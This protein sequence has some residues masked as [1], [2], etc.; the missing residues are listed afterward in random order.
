MQGEFELPTRLSV[1]A[2]DLILS[3]TEALTRSDSVSNC[4]DDKQK[5]AGIGERNRPVMLLPSTSTKK[6]VNK[7]SKS[8]ESTHMEMKL[9][10]WDQLDHLIVLV[11]RLTAVCSITCFIYSDLFIECHI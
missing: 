9:L 3:L 2:A 11:E 10:L 1:A 4:S 6:K 5:A 7:I 8:S